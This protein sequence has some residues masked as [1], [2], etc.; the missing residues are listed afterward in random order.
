MGR[1]RPDG[2]SSKAGG[3]VLLVSAVV[4]ALIVTQVALAGGRGEGTAESAAGGKAVK[5][6]RQQVKALSARV[7]ALE[8]GGGATGAAGG[9]LTGTYPNPSIAPNAVGGA[10]VD[11]SSLDSSVLQ[12]RNPTAFCNLGTAVS[13]FDADGDPACNDFPLTSGTQI[14]NDGCVLPTGTPTDCVST[15]VSTPRVRS[16]LILAT[17]VSG[18]AVAFDDPVSGTDSTTEVDAAC[19]IS[20]GGIGIGQT[21]DVSETQGGGGA[22]PS[23]GPKSFSVFAV[24]SVLPGGPY[25]YSLSCTENDP[26]IAIGI[27]SITAIVLGS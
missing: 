5:K 27:T 21:A 25:N 20:K 9:D 12:F 2:D 18:A 7:D 16:I 23:A 22:D 8:A 19:R 15:S 11:E 14:D 3:V 26:D 6:L 1:E 17:G 10:D 4:C 24:D 13:F